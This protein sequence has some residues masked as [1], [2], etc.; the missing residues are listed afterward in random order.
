MAR[1]FQKEGNPHYPLPP[2]YP[3]LGPEEQ[4]Q[5]RVNACCLQETPEDL[6]TAW[7]FFR[8]W[9]LL[10]PSLEIPGYF[11]RQWVESSPFHALCVYSLG[12]YP[13]NA[14]AAPRGSAKSTVLSLEIPLLFLLTRP[15]T[16]LLSLLVKDDFVIERASTIMQQLEENEY[17]LR[18]F[19]EMKPARGSGASWNRHAIQT[20]R[21]SKWEGMS[22]MGRK[23]GKRP[24]IILCD[25]PEYDPDAS[26]DQQLILERFS[27]M[28]F[29]HLLPMLRRQG[30]SFFWIGTLLNRRSFLYEVTQGSDPRFEHWNKIILAARWPD[31]TLLWPEMWS[32]ETLQEI[33]E[34]IGTAAFNAQYLN[35]PIAGDARVFELH[36]SYH[37]YRVVDMDEAYQKAPLTSKAIIKWGRPV[38]DHDGEVRTEELA[39]EFGRWASGLFR[40]ACVDQAFTTKKTSD[41]SCVLV[42]GFDSDGVEWVLDGFMGRVREDALIDQL[43]HLSKKWEVRIIGS[44][45]AGIQHN[46]AEQIKSGLA[47]RF[48]QWVPAVFPVRYRPGQPKEQRIMGLAWRFSQYKLR[49]PQHLARVWPFT[50]LIAQTENFTPDGKLLRYDDAIDTL[51]QTQYVIK[52]GSRYNKDAPPKILTPIDRM[53]EGIRTLEGTGI[54]LLHGINASEMTVEDVEAIR[55]AIGG[56]EWDDGDI[57]R[58]NWTSPIGGLI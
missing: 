54:P 11:Y 20:R 4:R 38:E 15:F 19:G 25:D 35:N 55:M 30:A 2:D 41:Y 16:Q 43:L 13:R 14:V 17:I 7:S 31:G 33:E 47:Q 39:K 45:M 22:V 5:A 6:V 28:L 57:D 37:Y 3:R 8:R 48:N 51:A 34:E 44:E 49:Y 18:D 36:P 52:P 56:F 10:Q 27:H 23:L 58:R 42:V 53:R 21:G 50:Q 9:Y 1:R 32:E 29:N 12:R 46:L 40:I 26:T 24:D